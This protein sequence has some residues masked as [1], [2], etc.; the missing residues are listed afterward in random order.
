MNRHDKRKRRKLARHGTP[1]EIFPPSQPHGPIQPEIHERMNKVADAL[2]LAFPGCDITL[3]VA[4][5]DATAGRKYPRFNY[6][7]TAAREDMVAVLKAFVAKNN[8]EA[9]KVD[10][11]MDPP[12][13]RTRQ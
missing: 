3:F 7:S 8:A 9:G 1:D 10:K 4:E 5:R 6:I 12:P 2:R 11:I 13:T